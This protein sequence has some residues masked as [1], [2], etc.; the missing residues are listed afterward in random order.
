ML[1]NW[2]H[3]HSLVYVGKISTG[4]KKLGAIVG[5]GAQIGCNVV[6]TPGTLIE[7]KGWV[8]PNDTLEGFLDTETSLGKIK[9]KSKQAKPRLK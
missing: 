7:K 6:L 4:L 1:A 2:K 5:D 8:Y 3:T 9:E